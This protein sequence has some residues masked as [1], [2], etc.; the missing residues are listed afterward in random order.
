MRGWFMGSMRS[1]FRGNLAPR[2]RGDISPSR[3]AQPQGC[4]RE[5]LH[6]K[7]GSEGIAAGRDGPPGGYRRLNLVQFSSI[8]FG[9]RR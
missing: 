8:W 2:W 6:P 5:F 7:R 9:L 3:A 4:V 1:W